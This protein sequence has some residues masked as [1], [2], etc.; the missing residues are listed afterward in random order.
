MAAKKKTP[1]KKQPFNEVTTG[2]EQPAKKGLL[3]ELR[4]LQDKGETS[5][6]H[7][8]KVL[9]E[10]EVLFGTGETNSFG[11][12]DITILKERLAK[13]GKAD[14]QQ[15]AKKVGINPFYNKEIVTANII[16]EFRR[17]QSRG[18]IFTAPLPEPALELDPNDP[19][20]KELRDWLNGS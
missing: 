18:N 20:Q 17:L 5:T 12:N 1:K 10:V 2:H 14:L 15:F 13:M 4:E 19:K 6:A 11:T 9:E 16:K 3:E 7:Y 8:R